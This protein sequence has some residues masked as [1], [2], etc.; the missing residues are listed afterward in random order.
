M[1]LD[2]YGI[3]NC[4]TVKKA[5]NWLDEHEIPYLFHDFKKTGADPLLL[6]KWC[7]DVGWEALVNKK[8]TTWRRLSPEIQTSIIDE[9]AAISLME[10]NT[11]VIKRPVIAHP[12][13]TVIGFNEEKYDTIFGQNS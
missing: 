5:L 6:Q 4:N 12:D 3:K 7:K 11:S 9:N 13:G 2:V 10:E 8:G 1:E